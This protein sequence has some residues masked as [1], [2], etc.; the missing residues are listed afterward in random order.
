M[1]KVKIVV[2]LMKIKGLMRKFAEK[3]KS[4]PQE[5]E[6]RFNSKFQMIKIF[7][8]M[9]E[10]LKTFSLIDKELQISLL[11]VN[12]EILKETLKQNVEKYFKIHL[13]HKIAIFSTQN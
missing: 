4:I 9:F 5:V 8:D 13:I 1:D 2:T 3:H 7:S 6:T 10:N 11:S 12:E